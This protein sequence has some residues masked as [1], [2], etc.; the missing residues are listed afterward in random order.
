MGE[1]RGTQQAERRVELMQE[2]AGQAREKAE[3]ARERAEQAQERAE[4]A[5]E[6]ADQAFED[7]EDDGDSEPGWHS[8]GTDGWHGHPTPPRPPR[9]PRPPHSGSAEPQ[10]AIDRLMSRLDELEHRFTEAQDR[11]ATFLNRF[12]PDDTS[13]D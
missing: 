7:A 12:R 5:Q 13:S 10:N 6:A 1:P 3:A 11:A 8:R 4:Q 2:R 9:P